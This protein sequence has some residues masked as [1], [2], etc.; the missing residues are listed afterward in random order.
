MSVMWSL[1]QQ[2]DIFYMIAL[3]NKPYIPELVRFC[4]HFVEVEE[5]FADIDEYPGSYRR[6]LF[7]FLGF[8]ILKC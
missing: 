3:Q 7:L 1:M 5:I 8:L 6:N 2:K 4:D